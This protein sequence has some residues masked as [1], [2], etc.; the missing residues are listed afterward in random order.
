MSTHCATIKLSKAD[1]VATM[2]RMTHDVLG[3]EKIS[4]DAL[5]TLRLQNLAKNWNRNPVGILAALKADYAANSNEQ[6]LA[7][8][9]EIAYLQA[10][11]AD[12][13]DNRSDAA[14]FYMM[15]CVHAYD[16]LFKRSE[17]CIRLAFDNRYYQIQRIYNFALGRYLSI[18]QAT[19][20]R[21]DDHQSGYLF[22]EVAV[23]ISDRCGSRPRDYYDQLMSA[24]EVNIRGL[25]NRYIH[26][27]LGAPLIAFRANR[28]S[29]PLEAYY[30]PE[31]IVHPITAVIRFDH[32]HVTGSGVPRRAMVHFLNPW[33]QNSLESGS[34]T[35]PLAADHTAP[36]A[37][38][39]D[40]ADFKRMSLGQLRNVK[41]MEK[42]Q[43]LFMLEPYDPQKTPVIMIHGLGATPATWMELT[44]DIYGRP[45][46]RDR[47]QVWHYIYPTGYPF[48]YSGAVLRK[49]IKDFREGVD[50]EGDDPAMASWVVVAHS[51]GG[52]LTR[53]L[54]SDSGKKIW[55]TAFT[56]PIDA[57]TL[58]QEENEYL[59]NTFTFFPAPFISRV[60]FVAVPHR[61]SRIAKS[62]IGRVGSSLVRLP[63]D[64]L[65]ML[66]GIHAKNRNAFQDSLAAV[67]TKRGPTSIKMLSPDQPLIQAM[68]NLPINAGVVV[69]SIMGDRGRNQLEGG[70]DGVVKYESSHLAGVAS[71]LVVPSGHDAHTHPLAIA[72]IQR[73]LVEHLAE[74]GPTKKQ[75]AAAAEE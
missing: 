63:G 50:P 42:R 73:I 41:A 40:L 20:G 12:R 67:L 11:N 26:H 48:L 74:P 70:S 30:P 52:L 62:F 4:E 45:D 19:T 9:T 21:L 44:N 36:F 66:S 17:H 25:R 33:E 3:T 14:I 56:Q 71:E 60:I 46:L 64:F 8:I 22:E 65:G 75:V 18:H 37:Y 55:K 68:A 72:E 24:T 29:D 23:Q 54:I 27:G 58:S 43:G 57:L 39:L 2:T 53:G 69:H 15:A 35:I 31:G 49:T 7:A 32:G 38:L 6:L 13:E 47:Y 28:N 61:G 1:P 59:S 34:G 51:M 16:Y 10:R 5:Q